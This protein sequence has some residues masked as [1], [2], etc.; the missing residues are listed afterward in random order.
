LC[1]LDTKPRDFTSADASLLRDLAKI[2]ESRL[3]IQQDI[4]DPLPILP[5]G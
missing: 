4:V 1:V 5:E 2:V 3:A